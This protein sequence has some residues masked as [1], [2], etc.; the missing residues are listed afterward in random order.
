M[1]VVDPIGTEAR[2]LLK[3]AESFIVHM[4]PIRLGLVFDTRAENDDTKDAYRGIVCAFNY[5]MQHQ[6]PRS[7]IG[8]LTDVCI[9]KIENCIL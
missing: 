9:R 4:A 2:P 1:L 3:L 7:A 8:F 6:S 5:M